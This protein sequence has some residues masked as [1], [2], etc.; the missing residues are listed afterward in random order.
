[1]LFARSIPPNHA[2]GT[3]STIPEIHD[4]TGACPG[5][6]IIAPMVKTASIT[7]MITACRTS[8]RR[9]SQ[10]VTYPPAT[11]HNIV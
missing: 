11:T 8:A 9:A 1:M 10:A 2:A 5:S 4:H 3:T 6:A 7:P